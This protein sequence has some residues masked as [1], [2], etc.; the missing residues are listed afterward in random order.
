MKKKEK[1][2]SRS[3]NSFLRQILTC[4]GIVPNCADSNS[5]QQQQTDQESDQLNRRD[6]RTSSSSRNLLTS[7]QKSMSQSAQHNL[8]SDEIFGLNDEQP[9]SLS[10]PSHWKSEESGFEGQQKSSGS[11]Q[12]R[13]QS[14]PRIPQSATGVDKNRSDYDDEE[15]DEEYEE[16]EGEE[17]QDADDDLD[18]EEEPYDDDED[19]APASTKK[20]NN[21]L[22]C[23]NNVTATASSGGKKMYESDEDLVEKK[24]KPYSKKLGDHQSQSRSSRNNSN[25]SSLKLS[26]SANPIICTPSSNLNESNASTGA[27][28]E[29]FTAAREI[30]SFSFHTD[31]QNDE[32]AQSNDDLLTSKHQIQQQQQQQQKSQQQPHLLP[33]SAFYSKFLTGSN[34]IT[35]RG[36]IVNV[37]TGSFNL[38]C[39]TNSPSSS[40]MSLMPGYL[41]GDLNDTELI[42]SDQFFSSLDHQYSSND[43]LRVTSSFYFSIN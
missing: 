36:C 9:M 2:K 21:L 23:N 10:I 20:S 41:Q 32:M 11:K 27:G 8:V 24:S 33:S 12:Q 25:R 37:R 4:G 28:I 29:L 31:D 15:E 13:Q 35:D 30:P 7:H 1:R 19:D 40:A 38:G 5:A 14:H 39:Q 6:S 18:D 3:A 16:N 26:S 42:N 22:I 17:E 43:F 34:I